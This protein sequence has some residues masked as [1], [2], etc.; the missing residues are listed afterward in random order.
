MEHFKNFSVYIGRG[1]VEAHSLFAWA[2][3]YGAVCR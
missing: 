3:T 1:C 2:G